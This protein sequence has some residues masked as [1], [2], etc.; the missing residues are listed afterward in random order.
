MKSFYKVSEVD[1]ESICNDVWDMVYD[2]RKQVE[3]KMKEDSLNKETKEQLSYEL[4]KLTK[5]AKLILICQNTKN[6]N[7]EPL[8]LVSL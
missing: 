5:L 3:L 2:R 8:K 1:Y 6:L 7:L 4:D